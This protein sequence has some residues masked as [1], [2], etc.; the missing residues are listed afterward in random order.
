MARACPGAADN[1]E[2][3]GSRTHPKMISNSRAFKAKRSTMLKDKSKSGQCKEA[4]LLDLS[5]IS[6]GSPLYL[7][8]TLPRVSQMSRK[9]MWTIQKRSD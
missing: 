8:Q 6:P 5:R 2:R 1:R 4:R 9:R 3:R 7:Q